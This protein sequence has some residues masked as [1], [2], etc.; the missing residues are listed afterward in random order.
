MTDILSASVRIAT[1]ILLAAL[2]GLLCFRAGVF[3][4]GLEGMMLIGSLAGVAGVIWSNGSVWAGDL[5]VACAGGAGLR[6][7]GARGSHGPA[8]G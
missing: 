7:A 8:A 5:G 2:G 6:M 4:I 1:P 3:N